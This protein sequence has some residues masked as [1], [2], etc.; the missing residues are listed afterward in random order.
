MAQPNWR[1]IYIGHG[2]ARRKKELLRIVKCWDNHL[3]IDFDQNMLGRGA[4]ICPDTKCKNLAT[5]K[6]GFDRS[7]RMEVE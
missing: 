4:C 7:I 6:R 1:S 3:E 2:Q 5:Q